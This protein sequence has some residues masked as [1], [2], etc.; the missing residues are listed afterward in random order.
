[1]KKNRVIFY[2]IAGFLATIGTGYSQVP[3]EDSTLVKQF[4]LDFA[5]PD[6]PAFK[7]L[8][9]NPSSILRPSSLTDLSL[10]TSEFMSGNSIVLPRSIS[11]EAAPV[12]LATANKV[13]LTSY[14]ENRMWHSL[15]LSLGTSFEEIDGNQ[16][17]NLS[18]GARISLIDKGDLKTDTAFLNELFRLTAESVKLKKDLQIQYL[19]MIG[20]T[21]FDYATDTAVQNATDKYVMEEIDKYKIESFDSRLERIK[22]EYKA[23]NWNK[24]KLDVAFALMTQSPDSLA[25]NIQFNSFGLWGTYALP[26]DTWGQVLLGINYMNMQ[27]A[28]LPETADTTVEM[29]R[30][31]LAS[32][33]YFGTNRIKGFLEA[34]YNYE[35]Y[36]NTSNALLNFGTELNPFN[37]IWLNFNAG[38]S[39]YNIFEENH[40]SA[41]FTSFDLRFQLPE[42]FKLF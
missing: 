21:M 33:L 9:T 26:V 39:F 40:S 32:R 38:Y 25:Q 31:A 15:R 13:T 12:M 2:L 16:A 34:E 4:R 1:M 3:S 37:G 24:A 8:G 20:K 35:D 30:L 41:L 10:I 28:P 19:D 22:L 27:Y 18:L 36:N 23:K 14:R 29:N 17:Y 42:K 11:I 5:V 7:L 6:Q